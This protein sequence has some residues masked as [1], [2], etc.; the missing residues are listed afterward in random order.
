MNKDTEVIK[1][2]AELGLNKNPKEISPE[3]Q[4][5]LDRLKDYEKEMGQ[6]LNPDTLT[7]YLSS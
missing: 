1:A 4:K 3:I 7:K 5:I 6:N 2:L